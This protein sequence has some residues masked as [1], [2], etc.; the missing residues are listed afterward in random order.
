MGYGWTFPVFSEGFIC[1]GEM[2]SF[3]ILSNALMGMAMTGIQFIHVFSTCSQGKKNPEVLQHV[4]L[5]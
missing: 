3:R 5:P 2:L 4:V 1:G